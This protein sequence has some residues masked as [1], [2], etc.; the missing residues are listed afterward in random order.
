MTAHTPTSAPKPRVACPRLC[1]LAIA[2][3]LLHTSCLLPQEL[4]EESES[5]LAFTPI[6]DERTGRFT[7]PVALVEHP[8]HDGHFFVVEQGGDILLLSPGT[9]GFDVST[10]A[11]IPVVMLELDGLLSLAFHPD[12]AENR[13]YYVVYNPAF[14]ELVV[15]E[16]F[17][18][19]SLAA[20][21][22]HSREILRVTH[23]WHGHNGGDL[24]F[25][26][27]GY[28]YIALGDGS[29]VTDYITDSQDLRTLHGKLLRIDVDNPTGGGQYGIPADNPFVNHED[30]L[31]RGEIWA[32]GLRS[33]WRMSFGPDGRLFLVDVGGG[34]QDEVNE[35]VKGGNYGWRVM[36]GTLCFNDSNLVSPLDSCDHEGMIDPIAIIEHPFP[37]SVC[38]VGGG[39]FRGDPASPLY[40]SYLFGDYKSR[41]IYAL[42]ETPGADEWNLGVIG[43]APA[44]MSSFAQ[45]RR[46]NVYLLGYYDGII[47]RIVH[48]GLTGQLTP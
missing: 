26:P 41:N 40:G 3:V 32:Y 15:E 27:D 29:I 17:A 45:D 1:V 44:S 33:P 13:K 23:R 2:T 16:R 31:V 20:D 46:G 21:D 24:V 25:G 6:N 11:H 19:A 28:L 36:E 35:I 5:S 12:F 37:Y 10:F 48:P 42:T 18:D 7:F 4:P 9:Q 39:V 22:G 30:V 8:A 34:L 38:L 14:G 47:Y 43:H